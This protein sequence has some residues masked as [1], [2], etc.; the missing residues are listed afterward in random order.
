MNLHWIERDK[1]LAV[2]TIQLSESVRIEA[3][4]YTYNNEEWYPEVQ[5]VRTEDEQDLPMFSIDDDPCDRLDEAKLT[6]QGFVD[7][8]DQHMDKEMGDLQ[9]K[10]DV[11][12]EAK[13]LF[14]GAT[15]NANRS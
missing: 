4:I 5:V 7:F 15:K 3:S 9:T 14:L 11:I 13:A 8:L 6:A 10:K 12:A 1:D 2:A